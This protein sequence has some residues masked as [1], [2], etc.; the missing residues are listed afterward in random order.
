MGKYRFGSWGVWS[1]NTD[2][3]SSLIRE[4]YKIAP[5]PLFYYNECDTALQ[6]QEENDFETSYPDFASR[7]TIYQVI[8][9]L[10]PKQQLETI[11]LAKPF[12]YYSAYSEED[13]L[14]FLRNAEDVGGA[15]YLKDT[16]DND[17]EVLFRGSL[18]ETALT[19]ASWHYNQDLYRG[20][21][22]LDNLYY[23]ETAREQLLHGVDTISEP[24]VQKAFEEEISNKDIF[25]FKCGVL[26]D[27]KV[28]EQ[29]NE[30][31]YKKVDVYENKKNW[32]YD[33]AVMMSESAYEKSFLVDT[34]SLVKRLA[35]EKVIASPELLEDAYGFNPCL[36]RMNG[37]REAVMKRH[38]V[39]IENDHI[40][41][42][43]DCPS[44]LLKGILF[45][46]AISSYSIHVKNGDLNSQQELMKVVSKNIRP[47]KHLSFYVSQTSQL[48]DA[49]Q[50]PDVE[51]FSLIGVAQNTHEVINTP[52]DLT[53]LKTKHLEIFRASEVKLP[54]TFES[55][56]WK[57]S[58]LQEV[59]KDLENKML[60]ALDLSRNSIE[61]L[62]EWLN[63]P[64]QTNLAYNNLK[65]IPEA[66][67]SLETTAYLN[68]FQNQ[69]EKVGEKA[70]QLIAFSHPH[71]ALELGMNRLNEHSVEEKQWEKLVGEIGLK[72]VKSSLLANQRF[73]KP[74]SIEFINQFQKEVEVNHLKI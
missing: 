37:I 20:H 53:E 72:N 48:L 56:T 29:I 22:P 39:F 26:L 23:L 67:I 15:G 18:Q 8:A 5:Q 61:K 21:E 57:Y 73:V 62:P 49:S 24:S 31:L 9:V 59:P 51:S 69:I 12:D 2:F 46:E 74:H 70:C 32:E 47:V 63:L 52:F 36:V 16:I 19:I 64:S 14:P 1:M 38:E 28:R 60:Y 10:S 13:I 54:E 68:L 65:E 6:I 17:M 35:V 58:N 41:L 43:D 27:R 11:V 34:N 71:K 4:G 3:A 30:H 42:N 45:T 66:K 25:L 55:L 7:M 44:E 50:I 40:S 33:D